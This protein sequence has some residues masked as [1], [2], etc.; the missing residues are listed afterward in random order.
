MS[1]Q[2]E[3]NETSNESCHYA[4]PDRVAEAI[5]ARY[6]GMEIKKSEDGDTIFVYEYD[7]KGII[8]EVAFFQIEEEVVLVIVRCTMK[9]N[10]LTEGGLRVLNN[11]NND[12]YL[13][14]HTLDISTRVYKCRC[15][16]PGCYMRERFCEVMDY[17]E[18]EYTKA[19]CLLSME[20]R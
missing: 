1:V 8:R 4:I 19:Q 3:W 17:I 9:R 14:T 20:C 10:E 2:P 7:G 15:V 5:T 12:K 11:L 18:A 13:I 16:V 6:C